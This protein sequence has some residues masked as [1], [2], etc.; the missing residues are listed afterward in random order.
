MTQTLSDE[1]RR[2]LIAAA[3]EARRFAYQP[4]SGFAVGAA[5][6]AQDGTIYTGCNVENASYGATI[7]AEQTAIVK[8]VSEGHKRF[9]AIAVVTENGI[10]PCGKCRQVLAEFGPEITV[11]MATPAGDVLDECTVRDLLPRAFGR[12]HLGRR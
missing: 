8:A 12:E 9:S 3:G 2:K 4:Y 6:L 10:S 5:L 7:C 1:S 11:I